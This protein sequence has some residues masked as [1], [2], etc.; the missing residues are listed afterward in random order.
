[1][2][3]K[4]DLAD[5]IVKMNYGELKQVAYELSETIKDKEVRPKLETSDEF[6]DLLYAWAEATRE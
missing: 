6:A 5:C 2:N 3:T 1:M 4:R